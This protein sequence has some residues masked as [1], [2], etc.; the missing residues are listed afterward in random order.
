MPLPP[1]WPRAA[2]AVAAAAPSTDINRAGA[3]GISGITRIVGSA[4][5]GRGGHGQ[6]HDRAAHAFGLSATWLQVE[7]GLITPEDVRE[8]LDGSQ[9]LDPFRVTTRQRVLG[10]DQLHD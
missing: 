7:L 3:A 10:P 2:K 4:A 6:S 9:S 1:A 5:G 8:A